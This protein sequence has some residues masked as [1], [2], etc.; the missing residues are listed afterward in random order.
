M[1]NLFANYWRSP[2]PQRVSTDEVIPVG[3]FDDTIIFRNFAFYALFNFDSVLAP[4]LLHDSL[5]GLINQP[6][7]NKLGARLRRNVRHGAR[8]VRKSTSS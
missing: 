6:G 2:Q 5:G 7:W 8:I 1:F 4:G 3:L